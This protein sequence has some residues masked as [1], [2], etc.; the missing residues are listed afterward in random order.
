MDISSKDFDELFRKIYEN[1]VLFV[2]RCTD[3]NN[4]KHLTPE[5]VSEVGRFR[6][7]YC[8]TLAVIVGNGKVMALQKLTDKTLFPDDEVPFLSDKARYDLMSHIEFFKNRVKLRSI[9]PE[10]MTDNGSINVGTSSL[11]YGSD[12]EK[13]YIQVTFPVESPLSDTDLVWHLRR[14][15]ITSLIT[16]LSLN[17]ITVD[18]RN[19]GSSSNDFLWDTASNQKS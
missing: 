6:H 10:W 18:P 3:V 7:M 5:D 15:L 2:G 8:G 4:P 12:L 1:V 19:T 14:A 13:F 16:E 11:T 17:V 9:L